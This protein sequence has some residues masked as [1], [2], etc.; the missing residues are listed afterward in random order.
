MNISFTLLGQFYIA[1]VILMTFFTV[2]FAKGKTENIVWV[3]FYSL[4]LNILL[5]PLGWIYCFYWSTR[6]NALVN[7]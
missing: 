5:P 1:L 4:L 6:A 7:Q 3:G 2:K